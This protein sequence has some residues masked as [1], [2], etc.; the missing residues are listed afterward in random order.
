LIVVWRGLNRLDHLDA[1]ESVSEFAFGD[2]RA[3]LRLGQVV[4]APPRGKPLS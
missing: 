4:L 1:G 3:G 2:D